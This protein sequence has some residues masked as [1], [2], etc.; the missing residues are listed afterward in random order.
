MFWELVRRTSPD[1]RDGHGM[2]RAPSTVWELS[3]DSNRYYS[4]PSIPPPTPSRRRASARRRVD[5]MGLSRSIQHRL[6]LQGVRSTC[7]LCLD[8]RRSTR[9]GSRR[10][11]VCGSFESSSTRPELVSAGPRRTS[12]RRRVVRGPGRAPTTCWWNGR[13]PKGPP[14]GPRRRRTPCGRRGTPRRVAA[15]PRRVPATTK[16]GAST[17]TLTLTRRPPR[18]RHARVRSTAAAPRAWWDTRAVR[19]MRVFF[20]GCGVYVYSYQAPLELSW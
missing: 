13:T 20:L 12:R 15:T 10:P 14:Q 3:I 8:A 11:R 19:L 2:V 5:G 16:C 1:P 9:S 18:R 17:K 4:R 6:H 7:C